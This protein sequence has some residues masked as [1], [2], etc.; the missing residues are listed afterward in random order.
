MFDERLKDLDKEILKQLKVI[1]IKQELKMNDSRFD[2][3]KKDNPNEID[4]EKLT[5][6]FDLISELML[7]QQIQLNRYEVDFQRMKSDIND[8]RQENR[9]LEISLSRIQR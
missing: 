2:F 4:I 5:D 7:K 6:I 3:C 9:Q 8:L 1:E